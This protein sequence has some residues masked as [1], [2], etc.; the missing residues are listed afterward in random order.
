MTA[1]VPPFNP[2]SNPNYDYVPHHRGSVVNRFAK[3]LRRPRPSD[4]IEDLPRCTGKSL[5]QRLHQFADL[6]RRADALV[7]HKDRLNLGEEYRERVA[8]MKGDL[9][10]IRK[11]GWD[12]R[13]EAKLISNFRAIVTLRTGVNEVR[14][15]R[16]QRRM[17]RRYDYR[18][19]EREFKAMVAQFWDEVRRE[20]SQGWEDIPRDEDPT[21]N[22]SFQIH[23]GKPPT[24]RFDYRDDF[25]PVDLDT[26]Q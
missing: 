23:N 13:I 21:E 22:G 19:F 15:S 25:G 24:K 1:Q 8:E 5:R 20:E 2:F 14:P 18:Q 3:G 26:D 4:G 17:N 7:K 10:T 16:D 12:R 6:V 9:R 11:N